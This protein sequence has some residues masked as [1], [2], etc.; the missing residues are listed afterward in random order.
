[1]MNI[2]FGTRSGD[3]VDKFAGL[4]AEPGPDGFPCSGSAPTGG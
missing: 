3:T 2:G 1:M 4:P